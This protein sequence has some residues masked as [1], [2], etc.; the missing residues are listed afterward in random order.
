MNNKTK[1]D[2]Y[3][4][5]FSRFLNGLPETER[6]D[7][8]D[9]IRAHLRRRADENR[10]E[11]TIRALGSPEQCAQGFY[12]QRQI[13]VALR[14]GGM[15]RTISTLLTFATKR[16]MAAIGLTMASVLFTF[17]VAFSGI[18]VTKIVVPQHV[19]LWI[20]PDKEFYRFG[21]TSTP[22][23]DGFTEILGLG[24]I[25]C[26]VFLAVATLAGAQIIARFFL[27]RLKA[28]LETRRRLI[29]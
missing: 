5:D 12:D 17:S 27:V 15:A 21:F 4:N 14:Q 19:G 3:L 20:T 9:E 8:I 6:A 18:A 10:L 11:E 28:P 26:A 1:I 24:M 13:E 23:V 22:P 25:P 29:Q 2:T 7:I 16:L